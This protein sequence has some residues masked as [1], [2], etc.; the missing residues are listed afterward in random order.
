[1][2][3]IADLS[4]NKE[5]LYCQVTEFQ[6][7]TDRNTLFSHES[8]IEREETSRSLITLSP[9]VSQ[10]LVQGTFLVEYLIPLENIVNIQNHLMNIEKTIKLYFNVYFIK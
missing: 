1:M 2:H 8:P 3:K 10:S 6:I 4:V 5:G 9:C 7:S